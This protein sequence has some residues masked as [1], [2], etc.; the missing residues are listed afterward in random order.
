MKHYFGGILRR[1][2]KP[3]EKFLI[4]SPY[5]YLSK[6]TAV[7][8]PPKTI[9]DQSYKKYSDMI[10]KGK[11]VKKLDIEIFNLVEEWKQYKIE[12]D[13]IYLNIKKVWNHIQD[14]N[15]AENEIYNGLIEFDKIINKLSAIISTQRSQHIEAFGDCQ[16]SGYSEVDDYETF[17][18]DTT[19]RVKVAKTI[20]K[21]MK[22]LII[23]VSE[24]QDRSAV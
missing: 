4:K 19:D 6:C 2:Y 3:C 21:K 17:T 18:K 5:L 9:E 8:R 10:E 22:A 7:H 24:F 11:I 20:T 13:K 12:D 14:M 23:R 15:E 16:Q 1:I